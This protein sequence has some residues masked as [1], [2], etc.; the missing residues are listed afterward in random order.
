MDIYELKAKYERQYLNG[1]LYLAKGDLALASNY[2]RV[3]MKNMQE[4]L[5]FVAG[6]EESEMRE[7]I[8]E[9]AGHLKD[10]NRLHKE[11]KER[12][13]SQEAQPQA[14]SKQQKET[15]Q[16][17]GFAF[18][19]E[20]VPDVSFADV[21]GL[22]NVKQQIRDMIINPKT[23]AELYKR[24]HKKMGGGVIMYGPPGNGKTMIAKAIAHETGATFF[25]IKFSD[26]GS[27]WFGETETNIKKLFEEA[28]KE[29]NAVIFFDEIDAIA[30]KRDGDTT[31]NRVVAELLTQMDGISKTSGN[32]TVLAAT[33]RL[34]DLDPAILRPG[35]FDEKLFIPLP[36]EK[37][38]AA[39]FK[40]R[41]KGIPCESMRFTE[42]AK[43]SEGFSGADVEL[44]CEKA[45]LSVIRSIING[46]SEE[47]AVTK[48]DL[49]DAIAAVN[50]N[51]NAV[52]I[53]IVE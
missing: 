15:E 9:L 51:K 52:N 40:R 30:P 43:A 17:T 14:V 25:P 12:K 53:I 6:A 18:K 4:C 36:D 35:R 5:P 26:L 13:E 45:K 46:A 16:E 3:A 44:A 20:N 49:L 22:E 34:Q 41:L 50:D 2:L 32:V 33:N 24:F 8:L 11:R 1:I 48:Q 38:R 23:Y 39:M 27:K 7:M 42:L 29:K 31:T 21:I 47:T 37:A 28:R 19:K 10:I